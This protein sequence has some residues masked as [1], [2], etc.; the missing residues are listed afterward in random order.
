MKTAKQLQS[1]LPE[2]TEPHLSSEANQV[3][4]KIPESRIHKGVL[5]IDAPIYEDDSKSVY[6]ATLTLRLMMTEESLRE[7][8]HSQGLAW[9]WLKTGKSI[10]LIEP[11]K[12]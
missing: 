9:G 1:E 3:V 11:S 8:A 12:N 7:W 10:R 2:I 4:K 6:K 5:Y